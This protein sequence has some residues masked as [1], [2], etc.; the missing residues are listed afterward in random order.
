VVP[1]PAGRRGPPDH[2]IAKADVV[3]KVKV[4]KAK[5]GKKV[6]A[7]IRAGSP[8]LTAPGKVAITYG[9]KKVG[10]KVLKNGK[11]TVQ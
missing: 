5:K 4:G 7:L 1:A 11:L 9:G 3:V 8:D 10:A 6:T 2:P